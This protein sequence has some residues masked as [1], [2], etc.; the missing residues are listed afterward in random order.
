M[1]FLSADIPA[2]LLHNWSTGKPGADMHLPP[3]N[4]FIATKFDLLPG[5]KAHTLADLS[6]EERTADF[7]GLPEI[8]VLAPELLIDEPD[9]RLFHR[10]DSSFGTPR[11]IANFKLTSSVL[12]Q[13]AATRAQ[14]MLMVD[15]LNDVV[16]EVVSQADLASLSAQISYEGPEGFQLSLYGFNDKL[17]TL[18][19]ALIEVRTTP[20]AVVF[21]HPLINPPMQEAPQHM[22]LTQSPGNSS[23]VLS[24]NHCCMFEQT[25]N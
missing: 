23:H 22:P 4:P 24:C 8:A 17:Q 20:E 21:W 13:S 25:R 9:L 19:V 14:G 10:A 5:A 16:N 6:S 7:E 1:D 11:A 3:P 18:A 2:A 12:W 15:C